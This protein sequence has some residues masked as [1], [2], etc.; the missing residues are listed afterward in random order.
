LLLFYLGRTLKFQSRGFPGP[1]PLF[2]LRTEACTLLTISRSSRKSR[3]E[4]TGEETKGE[5]YRKK[6]KNNV[7]CGNRRKK[8][9]KSG[10]EL[11]IAGQKA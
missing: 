10:R 7:V 1:R 4:K 2:A 5:Y 6:K 3:K 9:E 8:S 11:N